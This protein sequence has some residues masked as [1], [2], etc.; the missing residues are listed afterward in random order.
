MPRYEKGKR[1]RN[2]G[3]KRN[4]AGRPSLKKIEIKK[5][6]AVIAREFIEANVQPFLKAYKQ[7]ASGRWVNYHNRETGKLIYR[8]WEADA[9][10]TRHA[11]DKLLPEINAEKTNRPLAIQIIHNSR[12]SDVKA[13]RKGNSLSVHIGGE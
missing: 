2:Q 3:G 4:G 11:I 12:D 9:P 8:E 6:A 10:T 13:T 7:L 1:Q 5:E